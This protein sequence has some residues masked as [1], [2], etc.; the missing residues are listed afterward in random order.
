[1]L[2]KGFIEGESKP[3]LGCDASLQLHLRYCGGALQQPFE[4]FQDVP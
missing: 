1:M 3:W 4:E 2:V